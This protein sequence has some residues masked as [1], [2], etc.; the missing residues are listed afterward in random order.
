ML[1]NR[2]REIESD[3]T[4]SRKTKEV[5]VN[6]LW[7]IGAMVFISLFVNLCIR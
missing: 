1:T 2:G 4:V 7:L 5:L 3:E 6:C